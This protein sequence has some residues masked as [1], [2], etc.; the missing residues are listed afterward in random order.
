MIRTSFGT[1]KYCAFYVR[2]LVCNNADCLYLHARAEPADVISRVGITQKEL[3][4]SKELFKEQHDA[5]LEHLTKFTSKPLPPR[6]VSAKIVLPSVNSA[7][8]KLNDY[9][10]KTKSVKPKKEPILELQLTKWYA[11]LI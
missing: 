6:V 5:V 1:T 11:D 8:E 9:L 3:C 7:I 4:K 10:K 2:E